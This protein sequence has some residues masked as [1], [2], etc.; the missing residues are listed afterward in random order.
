MP[1]SDEDLK[2]AVAK[3]IEEEIAPMLALD[4]GG[5]KLLD[6]R[7]SVVYVQLL[8]GCV[9]CASAGNTLYTV[10]RKLATYFSPEIKV[11]NAPTGN[12]DDLQTIG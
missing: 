12:I 1:F 2:P 7:D 3:Y 9:G 6:V 11:V 5:I 10:E 4:G 8:G